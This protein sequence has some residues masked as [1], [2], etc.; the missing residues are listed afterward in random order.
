MGAERCLE[1]QYEPN[2]KTVDQKKN[3]YKKWGKS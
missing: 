3:D 1:K 2:M